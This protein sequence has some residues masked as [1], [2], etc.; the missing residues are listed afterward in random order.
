MPL[1]PAESLDEP[2]QGE[3]S[4]DQKTRKLLDESDGNQD[5]DTED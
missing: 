1:D 4:L 2:F 3:E 5:P